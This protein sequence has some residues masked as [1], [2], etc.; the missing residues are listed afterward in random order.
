MSRLACQV[1]FGMMKSN[2]FEHIN[3]RRLYSAACEA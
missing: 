2:T 1:E 3:Q